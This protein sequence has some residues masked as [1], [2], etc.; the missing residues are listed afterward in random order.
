VPDAGYLVELTDGVQYV[1]DGVSTVSV[2]DAVFLLGAQGTRMALAQV[3]TMTPV[4]G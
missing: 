1:W 4:G 3:V 2:G